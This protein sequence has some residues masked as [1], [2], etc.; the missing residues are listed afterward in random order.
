M[1]GFFRIGIWFAEDDA[2]TA[3]HEAGHLMG[4][5]DYFVDVPG[6]GS[7]SLPGWEGNLMAVGLTVDQ[8]NIEKILAATYGRGWAGRFSP[9]EI[10][11]MFGDYYVSD[12]GVPYINGIPEDLWVGGG[13]PSGPNYVGNRY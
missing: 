12:S 7:V 6:R 9:V 3:A 13:C 11:S 10:Q 5:E 1:V 2:Y 8:R 4:H